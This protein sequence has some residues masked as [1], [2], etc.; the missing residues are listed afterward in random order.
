MNYMQ[1]YDFYIIACSFAIIMTVQ[2]GEVSSR[3]TIVN[4]GIRTNTR[5]SY[6][7]TRALAA[8]VV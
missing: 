8:D 6:Y 3:K 4:F 5:P 2:N 7:T 1:F